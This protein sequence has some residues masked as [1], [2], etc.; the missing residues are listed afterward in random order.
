MRRE[1][2]SLGF[3]LSCLLA[4]ITVSEVVITGDSRTHS[5]DIQV[6]KDFK[7]G[8]NPGSIT[9]GSCLSSWDFSVDPCDYLFSDR[10]T[11]GFRCDRLVAG[12]SRVTEITLDQAGY[13]GTLSSSTWN[14]PFLQFLDLSD[15]SFSGSIPDSF[16][17]LTRLRRLTLSRNSF[18]GEIPNSLG[19]L[20][21]LEE[22]YLD[23][24]HL[25]GP[26]PASINGLISLK[27]LE[28]QEN[29]LSGAFPDLGSLKNLYFL[30]ASDNQ[31]SG[32]VTTA[33]PASLVELSIRNNNLEGKL[34]H[35]LGSLK[36]LQVMDMSDNKLSGVISWIVFDHPS[37]QQL[38]LS[39]NNFSL[40]QVPSN[41]GEGSKLIALDLSYNQLGGLLPAFI[42]SMPNLS[43]VSLEHNKFTGMIPSQY[44]L[45]TVVG[46]GG[47]TA[48][49]ERLLLG[50]NYLFGPIPGPLMFLK[51][52]YANVSLVDNCLYRCPNSFFF[53]QGGTQKSLVDCKNFR[54]SIP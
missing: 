12:V 37:L 52:G 51:P 38:T 14:L 8:L 21:N 20:P 25:Q 49:F 26:I 2:G 23:N 5:G 41:M 48:S 16:S 19:S 53:C 3:C 33:L 15:N 31:I 10:F 40:L 45:K 6:L 9:P 22:L 24:N 34:P 27:K 36:Y 32:Q 1:V 18:S 44:A 7:N 35:R 30:D 39:H 28:L 11:C 17:N 42:A 46:G 13:T 43:A 47:G 29:A 54:H 4:V 50:G